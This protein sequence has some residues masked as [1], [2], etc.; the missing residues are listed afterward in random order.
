MSTH[1]HSP[2]SQFRRLN[3]L[4]AEAALGSPQKLRQ[5]LVKHAIEAHNFLSSL[6]LNEFFQEHLGSELAG[7]LAQE[8]TGHLHIGFVAPTECTVELLAETAQR[9]CFNSAV[10]T[11]ASEVMAREL[12]LS[13]NQA[14]VPTTI[15]KAF[16]LSLADRSLGLEA[17]LPNTSVAE[18]KNWV[19]SGVGR[20]L[21]LGLQSRNA[22]CEAQKLCTQAGFHAPSFLKGKPAVNQAEDILVVYS[23]G[24]LEGRPLRLE[25]YHAASERPARA[26]QVGSGF[27]VV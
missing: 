13:S 15:L 18:S 25:F 26:V 27:R 19:Q 11:F 17:F 10:S 14:D 21:G 5:A 22:V 8:G 9:A 1:L 4:L 12:A 3:G 23:D 6:D 7:L 16:D 2:V 20:H 24:L